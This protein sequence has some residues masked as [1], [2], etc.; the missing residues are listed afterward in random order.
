MLAQDLKQKYIKF[1]QKKDH[2]VLPN[3]SLVPENDPT[4]LFINSGMHPLIPYLLG[5]THPLGSKLV[6]NQRCV[7]TGD[8]KEVGDTYHQTFF[9]ML[10]N[11]SLND[12][13][14]KE[15]L[16]WSWEFLTKTLSLDHKRLFISCFAG[17]KH[18]P[19][20]DEAAEIWQQLG[21]SRERIYFLGKKYGNWWSVGKT[22]PCGPCSEMYYDLGKKPCGSDCQPGCDCEKY[23]E[24]WNDVFMSFNRKPNGKLEK[25]KQKNI[26][27]GM[28]VDRTVAAL[29]E[30]GDNYQTE[31]FSPIIEKIENISGENYLKLVSEFSKSS[32]GRDSGWE[33]IQAFRVVADHARGAVFM[34]ADGVVPSNLEQ[35]YILRRLIRR[36]VRYGRRL[37]INDPFI[38]DLLHSVIKIYQDEYPHLKGAKNQVLSELVSEEKRFAK[39]LEKGLSEFNK[40][41]ISAPVA[42][43]NKLS[44]K[45]AFRLYETYG[46]PLELTQEMASEKGLAVD[47]GGFKKAQRQH[48]KKSRASLGKKFA[49]GL[50]D[51]SEIVTKL[52][53]A[54]HLL[55]QAL[56]QVLGDHVKQVGSN[57]TPER[58][59]FDFIHPEKVT[60]AEIEQIESIINKQI[61]ADLPVKM[62]MM[63][64]EEAKKKGALALFAQKYGQKVKA[65]S[66]GKFSFEVCGGPHVNSTGEIGGV[67]IFKEK[68]VGAGRR[69]LYA[70][71]INPKH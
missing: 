26:D 24:I 37:G 57:I 13:W 53:T 48:Q 19:R 30:H 34:A 9:E 59:R 3:V 45:L 2:E 23:I 71:L 63:S 49:G 68:V 27:T 56:R 18:S 50:A 38:S 22:G 64:P 4:A 28:G 52:H 67:R 51:H 17:D 8:I 65:Y 40:L 1:F 33:K 42:K 44:G 7:R 58:L 69:R 47:I 62:K 11:W 5:E 70:K 25:L 16:S 35:G 39:T 20:D 60:E 43:A 10:G 41:V 32:N 21:V 6:S 66:I 55:H 54:T 61:K 31:L 36:A 46:F 12:Y 29:Q 15:A 14:K